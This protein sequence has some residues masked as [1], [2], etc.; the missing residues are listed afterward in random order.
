MPPP[1]VRG[2]N[3][4]EAT[5]VSIQADAANVLESARAAALESAEQA[6]AEPVETGENNQRAK[7]LELLELEKE[8]TKILIGG[9]SR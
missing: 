3:T 2:I 4:F 5:S 6:D 1:T 9:K 8:K 7:E